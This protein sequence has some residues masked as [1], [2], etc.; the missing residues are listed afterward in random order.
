MIKD[1]KIN[2]VYLSPYSPNLNTLPESIGYTFSKI[3]VSDCIGWFH[4]C[5]II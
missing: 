2:V 1:L 4:S 5:N 3:C